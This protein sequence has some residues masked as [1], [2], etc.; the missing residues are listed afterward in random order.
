MRLASPFWGLAYE[1]LEMRY[2]SEVPHSLS[3]ERLDAI[4]PD[5]QPTARRDVMLAELPPQMRVNR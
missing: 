3:P 5:F 2:L 1:L 4:L